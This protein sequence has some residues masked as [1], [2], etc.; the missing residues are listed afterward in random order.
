M[1]NYSLL[2]FMQEVC[3]IL[4]TLS[5]PN[6]HT[7]THTQGKRYNKLKSRVRSNGGRIGKPEVER[8]CKHILQIK[9]EV[10]G[11]IIKS[12]PFKMQP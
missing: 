9:N 3:V 5:G 1:L 8:R 10:C 7:H 6:T 2:P 11:H 4:R 12:A